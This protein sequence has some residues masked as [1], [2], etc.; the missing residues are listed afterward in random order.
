MSATLQKQFLFARLLGVLLPEIHDRGYNVSLKHL[1]RCPEC[2]TGHPKSAHKSGM[3]ID[4]VLFMGEN[5]VWDDAPYASLHDVW[6]TH[7][8]AARIPGDLGHFSIQ[9]VEGVR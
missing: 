6:D 5:P 9:T 3:A 4:L 1:L 7:G 2:P 8:G